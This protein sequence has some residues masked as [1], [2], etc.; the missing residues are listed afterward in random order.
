LGTASVKPPRP[1]PRALPAYLRPGLELVFCGC[2]PG[3]YSAAAGHYFARPGNAFWPLL[4]E[5]GITPRRFRP[6]EDATLL[7]LG[8]GLTDAV[9][10]ATAGVGD[11]PAAEWSA[12]APRLAEELRAVR[13]AAV[14]F[15]GDRAYRAFSGR[16]RARWGRQPEMW[17]GIVI[18][19]T[20]STSGRAARLAAERRRAFEEVAE[21]LRDR[22]RTGEPDADHGGATASG[23]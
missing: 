20:P 5:T 22:R 8:I 15:V 3:L 13:P 6:D 7:A 19:V 12:A 10:R 11:V 4:A 14:C 2:N 23:R 18:F 17:E 9:L 21:W 16:S 1:E